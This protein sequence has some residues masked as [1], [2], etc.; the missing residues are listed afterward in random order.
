MLYVAIALD[1]AAQGIDGNTC[2]TCM[3]LITETLNKVPENSCQ[4]APME[5]CGCSRMLT[6]NDL[7][8]FSK[9]SLQQREGSSRGLLCFVCSGKRKIG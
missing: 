7:R 8:S 3:L 1:K 2:G 4:A 5:M 6:R 9:A